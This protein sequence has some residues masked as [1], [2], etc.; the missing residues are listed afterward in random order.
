M[1][2]T[3]LTIIFILL[4][5]ILAAVAIIAVALVMYSHGYDPTI[6]ELEDEDDE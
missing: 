3:I 5:A 2:T 4:A 6:E 1:E